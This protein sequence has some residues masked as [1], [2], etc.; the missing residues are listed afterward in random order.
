MLMY[1]LQ[2]AI[3][4]LR[5]KIDTARRTLLE[6]EEDLEWLKEQAT[7]MDVNF[8]RVHNVSVS[9]SSSGSF[10]VPAPSA[11]CFALLCAL[12]PWEMIVRAQ[13]K[14]DV[15]KKKNVIGRMSR[16]VLADE[17]MGDSF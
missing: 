9:S 7:V 16:R 13:R 3:D 15:K 4:L 11:F 14:G 10:L 12:Q 6:N 5:S 17:A 8:A 2:E 1:P